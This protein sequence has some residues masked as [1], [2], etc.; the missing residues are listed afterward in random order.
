M[1]APRFEC[2]SRAVTGFGHRHTLTRMQALEGGSPGTRSNGFRRRKVLNRDPGSARRPRTPRSSNTKALRHRAPPPCAGWNR[3][4]IPPWG[5]QGRGHRPRGAAAIPAVV[6]LSPLGV[7]PCQGTP[8]IP[9]NGCSPCSRKGVDAQPV[10]RGP[11]AS[12][13]LTW[14][15]VTG[16]GGGDAGAAGMRPG[17]VPTIALA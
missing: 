5:T 16:A 14:C 9:R 8:L 2:S 13:A 6:I 4:G 17:A 11:P 10:A 7:L 12:H 1:Q 3:S 15:G